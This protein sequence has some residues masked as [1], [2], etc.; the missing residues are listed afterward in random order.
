MK[1]RGFSRLIGLVSA[2]AAVTVVLT[3]T[4]PP[5][6]QAAPTTQTIAQAAA[7]TASTATASTATIKQAGTTHAA[8]SSQATAKQATTSSQATAKQATATRASVSQ[9]GAAQVG[10]AQASRKAQAQGAE[11]MQPS[12]S[13]A[14]CPAANPSAASAPTPSA[15]AEV[16]AIAGSASATVVWCPPATGAAHVVSYTVTSSSGQ[17]VTAKVPNDWAIIDGL[18]D[19]TSY[20]FTV[21]ATTKTKQLSPPATSN[22]IKPAPI[23]PPSGV[24]RGQPQTVGYNGY[25]MKINGSPVFI[26][27]GEFDPFRTPSP[28]L[29]LDDLQ[30][31]K[32]DGY[33]AVTVYFDWDY[34]SPSPGVYDFT[35]VRDMNLFL[36]MAQQAGLYVIARPGPYINAETDGG[37]IPAWLL[38]AP[39]GFRTDTQPYLNAARQ[40]FSEIDPIIAAHQITKGGDVIA[41]Q[42]E[43]EYTGSSKGDV[44]YMADLEDQA[45]QD[46][47]DVPFTFNQCCGALT[48]TTGKAK[49]NI[50][51]T[52]NYP[53]GF[54]CEDPSNFAQPY[55]YPQYK[56]MP[57]YLPEFQGGSFDGWGGAGYNKCYTRTGPDFEN[58]FYKNNIAQGVT[59]Q[60][61]YMGVGGTNWGWLPDP[62]VYT[63]YDYG[64]AI[65]ETGEI[66]TPAN[67]NAIAGSKYG[68]NKL[69]NDFETTAAPL[70][71]TTPVAAPPSSNPAVVTMQRANPGDHAQFIYVRQAN[72]SSTATVHTHLALNTDETDSYT[73]D[74]TSSA[75]T[76]AGTWTHAGPTSGYTQGDYDQ[77]ES[78][79]QQA[80]ASM[81]LTFTGTA[82]E[83]IGPAN[84]NGGIAD[85]YID[86]NLAG[87]VDTYAAAGKTFQQVLFFKRGL[88]AGQHTLKIV[89][90]GTQNPASSADTVVIDAINIPYGAAQAAY[91]PQIPQQAGTSITLRGRDS[92]LLVANYSFAGQHLDYS[93]SELADLT[94]A[95]R[96]T[97]S[98]GSGGS[99][100]RAGTGSGDR[101]VALF[102]DPAGTDGETEFSYASQPTVKVLAGSVRSTWQPGRH[103]L[104][105]D[106]VHK[107][108]A[109]V[110]ITGGG[111]PPML[112]LLADTNT[113]EDF[114][115]EQTSAGPALVEGGYLVRT[116]SVD[117]GGVLALTGDTT[118][119]GGPLT[120]WAPPGIRAVT[121]NGRLAAIPRGQ[122]GALRG[123]I[124][125]PVPVSLPA[126]TNWKFSYETPEA[127]PGFDDSSWTLADHPVSTQGGRAKGGP[128]LFAS[129][130]GYDHGFVWYRG[131]FTATGGETGVTLTADG[132]APT[133]AFS[134][135]LNGAF[136]GSNTAAGPSTATFSFPP[137]VVKPGADNVIAVLV[138]N[139]DRPEGPSAEP[140][141]LYTASLQGSSAPVTWRL[142]GNQGGTTL[143]DPVRGPLNAAGLYGTNNG[144]DLPGY[145]DQDWQ[146][147]TLPDSWSARGV[148]PGVGWYRTS[149]S[150]GLP[151]QS[152]VPVDVQIGGPGPGAGTANYRAFIFVNGWM[153]GR[154]V[155]NVGPQHQF[156]V[157][158]GLLNDDGPNTL[159]IAVWGLDETSGG[160]PKVSLVA[161]GD[162]AGGVPVFPVASPGY[163]PAVYGPPAA[164]QPTLAATP[165]TAL[166][167]G[168]FTVKATLRNPTW[169]P[170]SG[171]SA[172]LSVPSGWT[173][174][175]AG[176]QS[177]GSV[178]LGT[179]APGASATAK[180]RVTPPASG[181][182]PGTAGVTATA[183]FTAGSGG[184][185][186]LANAADVTVPAASLAAT[187]DN[188]GITDDSDTDPTPGFIGFDGEGT[189]FSAQGLAADGLTPGASV[190]AG[191]LS[192]TWPGVA[193]AEP[194][195]TM[196]QGQA[197]A[198]SGSGSSLGFLVAAN[199]S[200]E[201]GTGTVYY[202][203]GTHQT[204][205]L[206]AGNFWDPAGQ[207][208]NPDNVQVAG[209]NYANYPTGSSGHEV[210]VFEQSVPIDASKTVAAVVLPSLGSVAG[211]NAALH[212]FALSIG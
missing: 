177:L 13:D 100:P 19:G 7:A 58:V 126:L 179:V 73:Y 39:N 96:S 59:M 64:A 107:G 76:Y 61:N 82:V 20:T 184:T 200:A 51:G 147:V 196:A 18:T 144:W 159:S 172:T 192:F 160:L 155:N 124:G 77:T 176:A 42:I 43:N 22:P 97:A 167:Q 112:L 123:V 102:Y 202:T 206:A 24:I 80:G 157:P 40:W 127:Q 25:A 10:K 33:D 109:E 52:D 135:W 143:Q 32:S 170:L 36:N 50:S 5:A 23:Q 168:S 21:T 138:E 199:N 198:I 53:L 6:A 103:G 208:G 15:P 69:I 169:Q 56:G 185:Q 209:V 175:P 161:M 136:L 47:I 92:R 174:S 212:V 158:A 171:A 148:P 133:G 67:P 128:V 146:N 29:W 120:V 72:A 182:S 83:W 156:Y 137:G 26:T 194:D 186:S 37:G 117:Q 104:R 99:S 189:S 75:L 1:R 129:D 84:T 142:M 113:A 114:W 204:F 3:L 139:T 205:T 88:P 164:P 110:S 45:S 150:L 78:W 130:Y 14:S 119:V 98:G 30:K 134:V 48:F 81:S 85:V 132:I 145:P 181:L 94:S 87:T 131:H 190:S 41:Y 149:F 203:D 197:I 95:G 44:Q 178:A 68:E 166:A 140:V 11:P 63:S 151:R 125:M 74:D 183:T 28:S 70:T 111:R 60:S 195:N 201:S 210:Y 122:D 54:D 71:S 86:G 31:M 34:Q 105:L 118:T 116:A 90:T 154:Y 16:K 65:R 62:D 115:P 101:T 193:S 57:I 12:G 46:G 141:G 121:W 27:A 79:S 188:T 207:D 4:S 152:Y 180:F 91:F 211:Y 173:V 153:I 191:G 66:G 93:T 108:L 9:A 163:N 49:V 17:H 106:Y 187:F 8:T 165:S 162:Q 89:V 35:G 55:S 2:P 38:T